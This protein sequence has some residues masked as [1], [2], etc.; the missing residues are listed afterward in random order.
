[1][2]AISTP[3]LVL[4]RYVEGISNAEDL[5]NPETKNAALFELD[6]AIKHCHE[7]D[8]HLAHYA[9]E[10]DGEPQ[11]SPRLRKTSLASLR[12]LGADVKV[13]SLPIDWDHKVKWTEELMEDVWKRID[14][15]SNDPVLGQWAYCYTTRG[16]I[17]WIYQLE[18]PVSPEEAG[19][20]MMGLVEMWR[21]QGFKVDALKDWTR[22]FRLPSVLRDGERTESQWYFKLK[23]KPSRAVNPQLLPRVGSKE[24]EIYVEGDEVEGDMPPIDAV[25]LLVQTTKVANR[26]WLTLAM[27]KL[28]G[29]RC[30][31][32]V[33]Q[34]AGFG[35]AGEQNN[36]MLIYIGEIVQACFGIEGTTPELCYGLLV[37]A[38]EQCEIVKAGG[39]TP[40]EQLWRM[41]KHA[42]KAES[43]KRK[44]RAIEESAEARE[45]LEE[46]M[47]LRERV[48]KGQ[49]V[50][51]K[52]LHHLSLDDAWDIVSTRLI[53]RNARK[54]IAIVTPDGTYE[55][56]RHSDILRRASRDAGVESLFQWNFED[57]KGV[58]KTVTD[59]Q[60]LSEHCFDV[61]NVYVQQT[62]QPGF[63]L[64]GNNAIRNHVEVVKLAP[65][66]NEQVDRWLTLLGG[67]QTD[68]LKL[69]LSHYLDLSR[70]I[71]SLAMIGPPNIGKS[72]LIE[73]LRDCFEGGGV[74]DFSS[75]VG[76]YQ[77][78]MLDTPLVVADET[79]GLGRRAIETSNLIRQLVTG[80]PRT[81]NNKYEV[82]VTVTANWR[83]VCA[84]NSDDL[85]HELYANNAISIEDRRAIA[86]RVLLLD[87]DSKASK[88]LAKLGGRAHTGR[89]GAEWVGGA[90]ILAKHFLYMFENRPAV[91]L[92]SRLLVEGNLDSRFAEVLRAGV[93]DNH[94]V[95][96]AILQ[97]LNQQELSPGLGVRIHE[98][99]G[100]LVS[101][102]G[103]VRV[104]METDK[105][106]QA[107]AYRRARKVIKSLCLESKNYMLDGLRWYH[108]DT[109]LFAK[110]AS[111]YGFDRAYAHLKK[112]TK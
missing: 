47:S 95:A 9:L 31:G 3:C 23:S 45:A 69:W 98:D 53:I 108:V 25:K 27:Q 6:D 77:P 106:S 105:L 63:I 89:E 72:M 29:K 14:R 74:C 20:L 4:N 8:A 67:A 109:G 41:T 58:V 107:M 84:G 22:L 26:M 75:I 97:L 52:R 59:R 13:H 61:D 42:W 80:Q 18:Y 10:I 11:E 71:A 34:V 57:E 33:N 55:R 90:K 103:V 15:V 94:S 79:F 24:E 19:S 93:G 82:Q 62:D 50:W 28:Q 39:E 104:V 83:L 73:G 12:A 112:F 56:W 46:E 5:A 64:R 51:D 96:L 85:L 21:T 32:T 92:G 60:I 35:A 48:I 111:E 88:Y 1:L 102:R 54:Q 91:V 2:Q 110:M 16:G 37:P 44:Q 87:C 43:A 68:M 30:F 78:G 99:H 36:N 40:L 49:A 65:Q 86:Q 70:P 101:L 76:D 66:Y 100:V 7:F 81:V 17:H 38:A